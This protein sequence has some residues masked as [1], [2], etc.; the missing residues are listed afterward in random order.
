MPN[1]RQATCH[2]GQLRVVCEGDPVRVSMCHCL[3]CQRRTGSVF[4]VQ[5]RFKQEQVRVEGARKEYRRV[6]DTNTPVTLYFCPECGSTVYW[7]LSGL[8]GF[9]A[10][11]V[12]AFSDPSFP[13]PTVS[14]YGLRRHPWAL[15]PEGMIQENWD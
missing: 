10:V 2:C 8:P 14:V 4:G 12:G 3:L 9:V 1:T 15:T 6:G 5:A 11:A 13:H 7:E